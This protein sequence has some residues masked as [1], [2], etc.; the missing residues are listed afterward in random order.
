MGKLSKEQ[1]V[2]RRQQLRLDA[3]REIA[4]TEVLQFRLDK[5]AIDRIHR[6]ADQEQIAV[7][8]MLRKWVMERVAIEENGSSRSPVD[9]ADQIERVSSQLVKEAIEKEHSYLTSIKRLNE[10]ILN[11]VQQLRSEKQ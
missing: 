1:L 4:K 7:G 9:F 6:L 11:E 8:T 10:E 2:Q 5:D 3:Q